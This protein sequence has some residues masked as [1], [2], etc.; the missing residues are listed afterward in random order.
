MSRFRIALA[1][2]FALALLAGAS[3]PAGAASQG[4]TYY[5]CTI[6]IS[7]ATHDCTNG[8][9]TVTS[10]SGSQRVARVNL[11]PSYLRLDAFVDVCTPTGWW[12]HLGDS[13]SSNGGGGDGSHTEHDAE[14]YV[15]GTNFEMYG[16]YNYSRGGI[17]VVHRSEAVVP[18]SGCYRVQWTVFESRA[19]FDDD[20]NPADTP[21]VEA[22][23]THGFESAPYDEP[24]SEDDTAAD[25]N[26]WYVGMNRTVGTS[27]RSGTGVSKVCFVVSTTTSPTAALLSSLCP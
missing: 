25:A 16:M 15:L 10:S 2:A 1:A 18:A 26:L 12:I 21:R 3:A 5:Q 17:E 23:S 14:A 20:G 24:D 11:A 13:P 27:S 9:V 4:S 8:I 19:M 6:N 7:G 22:R